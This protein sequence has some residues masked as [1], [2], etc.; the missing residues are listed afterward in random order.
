M[1]LTDFFS[2]FNLQFVGG[3]HPATTGPTAQSRNPRGG[4]HFARDVHLMSVCPDPKPIKN[5]PL[6]IR[7]KVYMSP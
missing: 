1:F 6:G 3:P 5:S 7:Q 4:E 2:K